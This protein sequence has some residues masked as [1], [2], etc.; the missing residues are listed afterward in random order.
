MT[1]YGAEIM[2]A[3]YNTHGR[4]VLHVRLR[5]REGI[6]DYEVPRCKVMLLLIEFGVGTSF[7]LRRQKVDT[8]CINDRVELIMPSI[9]QR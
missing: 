3:F 7:R 8:L 5:S 4:D 1:T 6:M 9:P 2:Y